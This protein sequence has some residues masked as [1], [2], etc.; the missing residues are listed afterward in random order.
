[1]TRIRLV[2]PE[3]KKATTISA[4]TNLGMIWNSSVTRMSN[5]STQPPKKPL[6]APTRMPIRVAV[7]AAARPTISETRDPQ[8]TP[9]RTSR[10]RW[11]VPR[12]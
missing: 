11:S 6:T 8:I 10:P 7:K 12:G 3:P 9:E 5:S 2:S 1:M 4:S